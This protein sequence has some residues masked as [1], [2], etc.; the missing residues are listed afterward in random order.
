MIVNKSLKNLARFT[1]LGM[2]VM[3]QN[4]IHEEIKEQFKLEECWLPF[5]SGYFVFSSP[6]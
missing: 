3:N 4:C 1:Y 5:S 6:L 2:T